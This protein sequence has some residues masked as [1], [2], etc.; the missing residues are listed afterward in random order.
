M[1]GTQG[2][3]LTIEE[4]EPQPLLTLDPIPN[5][6]EGAEGVTVTARL[7]NP[8]M[9]APR[10]EAPVTVSLGRLDTSQADQADFELSATTL[11]IQPGSSVA[12]FKLTANTDP[13]YEGDESL[14]LELSSP[15]ISGTIA[16]R[17]SLKIIDA[18][19]PPTLS[20]DPTG[21]LNEGD[22]VVVT[23]RLSGA[24]QDTVTVVL[25]VAP[26]DGTAGNAIEADY[27][28]AA[29]DAV[30]EPGQR[31]ATFRLEVSEDQIYEG[32]EQ[33]V[34]VPSVMNVGT[35]GVSLTAAADVQVTI[36][37]GEERPTLSLDPIEDVEEGN[38]VTVT[39]RLSGALA[40]PLTIPLTVEP[41][42][43]PDSA[44]VDD[45]AAP[46]QDVTISAGTTTVVFTLL[47]NDDSIYEGDERLTLRLETATLTVGFGTVEQ[48][49]TII[50]NDEAPVPVVEIGF[51]PV[52]YSV[53]EASGTV[54][55]TVEV[56]NG[57]LTD[58]VV[59][60]Y[61]TMDDSATSP[62][63]YTSVASTLTLSAMTPSV[64]FNVAIFDDVA[65]ELNETFTVT[66]DS[67]PAGV[68]LILSTATVTII[69][70]DEAPVVPE[71]PEV[72]VVTATLRVSELSVSEGDT[73]TLNIELSESTSEDVTLTLTVVAGG[74]AVES[75][76]YEPLLVPVVIR[77]GL[78]EL[79]VS[80]RTI[81]DDVTEETETFELVLSVV[82]GPAVIGA[83]DRVTVTILDDDEA[84]VV[85]VVP[86]LPEVVVVTATLRVSELSV[87]EGDTAT[88]NIELSEPTSEDVTLTLTV[89]AGGS[90]DVTVDYEP[91]L[92]PVV[93]RAGLSELTVSI[94][95]IDDDVTEETET[96]ELV[97]SVLSGPAVTG[98]VDRVTVTIL[99]DD[100]A[101]VVPVV[102][103]LPEV[104]VVTAT[105][106]V[107][108]LSVSEGDTATLNIELSEPTSE[109]VTL[110]LTV[111]AGG[112]ADVT[113][114]Y[115]P[116]LVPVVIRAGLSELTV[117]IRT[118]DD[119]VT[120][121]TET[122]E[123]VLSVLSGPAVAGA[124]D[125]VT[126][127]IL[128]DDVPVVPELPEVVVVTATLRVSEL[129]V[130]EGDTA[131]LNIELSEPA[132][133]DVTL[134]LTVAGGS[135]V[136]SVDYE[137]L[138]VPVVIRAGVLE[139][140]V[141]IRTIED[142]LTEATET[143]V[144]ELSVLSGPA[145][146]GAVDRVTVTILDDDEAPVVPVVPELPEVVVVTAT[147]RVS[148]LSVSEGDTATLNI[149]LSEVASEDVTLTLTVVVGGSRG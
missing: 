71:P 92:V 146:T 78:S 48:E 67:A 105:L 117:S 70:D 64:T 31:V 29:I 93:I 139:L 147:L 24:L 68:V 12:E 1:A 96:F 36:I 39:V 18:N 74:S 23:V 90:A 116:L 127:T 128:D 126:V 148:E 14:T 118:I 95:T 42:S 131:T 61:T 32:N 11:V 40:V 120:E 81:D 83:V 57:T 136:E 113:V 26:S 20:I 21:D 45:Y 79:T 94:R 54:E 121:E 77:A 102:P 135:A 138:L 103:E 35:V 132:S 142:D 46:P 73:A 4:D 28:L 2:T 109:D 100:E 110:T 52:T 69:D 134:T 16:S 115:D 114:D 98:A 7:I 63:D 6:E 88:L 141:S 85:P 122:F 143:L 82:D 59:L 8:D 33:L 5:I 62:G 104:V 37:D 144:L 76:D 9:T 133:E 51:D 38:S 49:L 129:S 3:V 25:A 56:I 84:P 87:S 107:S 125:R 130:S 44:D 119:D 106:R 89:V 34:L 65:Q 50:E 43:A 19:Q 111:V 97:L 112:S 53:G 101:P 47:T 10:L 99:D 66:L 30:V 91:L 86:E 140:T 124:A 108:E 55:L 27:S 149:E 15:Q 72:V 17:Q 58:E 60:S 41:G 22:R 145:V 75:A 123:L 80:I 13:T 137:P